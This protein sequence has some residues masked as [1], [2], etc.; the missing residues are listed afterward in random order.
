M[1]LGEV[2]I[3]IIYLTVCSLWIAISDR[4]LFL[5]SEQ[6][7]PAQI[8]L[9]ASSKGVFFVLI[10]TVLLWY[11][12]K[13]N[14]KKLI[15]GERQYRQMYEGSPLPKW[16]YD[17]QTLQIVSVNDT[18][19]ACYGY[20]REEFLQKSILDIR[21]ECDRER[22]LE[23]VKTVSPNLRQSGLFTH[24]KA[25]G[26]SISVSIGSQ[27]IEFANK[28]HVMITAQD[29]TEKLLYETKLKLL[30]EELLEERNKL[31]ETQQIAKVGGWEFYLDNRHLVWSDEMYIIAGLSP[32]S[33]LN[34]YDL[35][36]QQVN[37]EDR[38]LIVS[39]IEELIKTGK[40]LD[41]VHRIDLLDG[42]TRYIRQ[43]AKL[44]RTPDDKPYKLIGSAQDVTEVKLLE[45]ERNK[46]L[47][48]L[49]DTLNSINEGFYTL[50]YDLVFTKVNK[51]F[52]LE[53]GLTS[54]DVIGKGLKEVFPGIE[55]RLTYTQYSKALENNMPVRFEAYWRHFKKW[56]YVEA[57]P[58]GEGIAVY[59]I[60]ITDKK[61]KDI[62]LKEAI[63]RYETV[64]KATKDVIYDLNVLNGELKFYTD[65]SG[66][67]GCEPEDIGNTL[68]WWRSQTHPDDIKKVLDSQR[69]VLNK[70]ET[71]WQCEYRVRCGKSNEYRNVY[72]QGFYVYN[73]DYEAIKL[74]GAVKDIDELKRTSE[75]NKRLAD[76]ITKINNMV[77]LMA[78]D[79]SITWAN[80]AFE[81]Y[82]GYTLNELKGKSPGSV[83]GGDRLPPGTIEEI[84]RRKENLETFTIDLQHH[85]HSGVSQW[86]N[87]EYTPLF[88]DNGLHTG[89]IAVHQNI[90][91]RKAREVKIY[92]Q[93]KVLQEI[94]WMSSHEIRR[95]VASILGLA[96]LAKDT[97]AV[98]DR[99]QI[100]E[101]I[102][103]CAEEL[104]DIVHTITNKISTELYTGKDSIELKELD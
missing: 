3:S 52:E 81:E 15:D 2:G 99:E 90:T 25:D 82:T 39:G 61:E 57:Y 12:I 30:N 79:H 78:V 86:V 67:L 50:N 9:I 66:L 23:G 42:N 10:T 104:D 6:F 74:I 32:D 100:I 36:L 54:A 44:V 77:I 60:D 75:E 8:E 27:Q 45:Q 29:V 7:T 18:A 84:R 58:T 63:S 56:Q 13:R 89:Y 69:M 49:E 53:T 55:G 48:N 71:N 92:Q 85:L 43:M 96:Y 4:I 20:S 14:N 91:D 34:L 73:S 22:V 26:S 68:E 101:M 93:N 28:P 31:S 102:N 1:R 94:S 103:T 97:K 70:G 37:Q 76:I 16:I 62:L 41:V 5:F 51:K 11:L 24:N 35:F 64:S 40:Q 83:L 80:K 19:I 72:S 65:V 95:P 46:Y 17:P 59:F 88:D 87:I 38:P 98:D 47:F 21:P 33:G